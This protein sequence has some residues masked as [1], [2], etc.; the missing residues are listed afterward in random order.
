MHPIN[1]SSSK[2]SRSRPLQQ[3]FVAIDNKN[4]LIA[5]KTFF[6]CDCALV[7]PN[8][9]G[10]FLGTIEKGLDAIAQSHFL[11]CSFSSSYLTAKYVLFFQVAAG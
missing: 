8:D 6:K 4:D 10:W 7:R 5:G 11:D 2:S 1:A 3:L 9:A